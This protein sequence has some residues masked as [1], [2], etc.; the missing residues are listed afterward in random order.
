M[1]RDGSEVLTRTTALGLIVVASL[2][3]PASATASPRHTNGG[4]LNVDCPSARACTALG[5]HDAK[6]Q[7]VGI[8]AGAGRWDR[9]NTLLLPTDESLRGPGPEACER[10][11]QPMPTAATSN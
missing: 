9:R 10:L 4:L 3:W 6:K 5:Y 1:S 11:C 2:A 7:S 8:F